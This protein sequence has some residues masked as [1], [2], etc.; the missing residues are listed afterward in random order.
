MNE[1]LKRLVAWFEAYHVT[2]KELKLSECE[3]IFD[4]D[5]FIDAHLRSIK[6][7]FD[8]PTFAADI[9][10]MKRLKVKLEEIQD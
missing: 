5:L 8:N 10:R 1:E 4:L 6:R 9:E 7:N 3:N 2:V